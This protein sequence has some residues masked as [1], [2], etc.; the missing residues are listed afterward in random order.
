LHEE[1]KSAEVELS[2]ILAEKE[3]S[4]A[5]VVNMKPGDIIPFDMPEEVTLFAE[6]IAVFKGKLGVSNEQM[7]IQ[8]SQRSPRMIEKDTLEIARRRK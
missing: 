2:S 5:D 3:L 6:K 8:I 1:I 7:A 4:V